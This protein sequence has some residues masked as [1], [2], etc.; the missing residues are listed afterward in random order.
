MWKR[1]WPLIKYT[2]ASHVRVRE[3]LRAD[4]SS[5]KPEMK[6]RRVSEADGGKVPKKEGKAR[7]TGSEG[8]HYTCIYYC[9]IIMDGFRHELDRYRS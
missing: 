5:Q 2:R 7:S 8:S 3:S 6:V 1:S 9:Y 4:R